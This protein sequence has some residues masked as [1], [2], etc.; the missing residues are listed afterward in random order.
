MAGGRLADS[1][2][3]A[4]ESVAEKSVVLR[5]GSQSSLS[6]VCVLPVLARR[7]SSLLVLTC[8][9]ADCVVVCEWAASEQQREGAEAAT[10]DEAKPTRRSGSSCASAASLIR[11]HFQAIQQHSGGWRLW[12]L[13][14]DAAG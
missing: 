2:R 7:P 4:E 8:C 5:S 9:R 14:R 13:L 12:R 11:T 3:A 1:M 10:A 6:A